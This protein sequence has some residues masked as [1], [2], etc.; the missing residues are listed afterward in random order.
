MERQK[1]LRTQKIHTRFFGLFKS[2]RWRALFGIALISLTALPLSL[3][4]DVQ[5][6]QALPCV[7]TVFTNPSGNFNFSEGS[8]LELGFKFSASVDGYITGV[9]FYKQGSMGGTHVGR[10]WTSGG[11]PITSATFTSETASGWQE[12]SFSSPVEITANTTYV[13]SVTMND[14]NYTSTSNGFSSAITNG[15]LTAPSSASSGGNGVFSVNA[16]EFPASTFNATNYWIDVSFFDETAPQVSSVTPTDASTNVAPGEIVTATF[17]Q[18]L[19]SSTITSSTFTVQ[20]SDSNPVSGT[21]SY[22]ASTKTASFKTPNGFTLGETYT[23][24]L[25]G[26]TIVNGAGLALASDYV[27]SFTITATEVCPC[28][29]KAR[30]GAGRIYDD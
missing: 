8:D 3:I 22:T 2:W 25:E 24:T 1:Y 27:W 16:G 26:G 6:A 12:V 9:R 18:S 14:G 7:C 28:T 21:V 17:D 20:D 15:P 30:A 29:L 4:I 11:S 10:L 23:A 19:N 13:A 5:K